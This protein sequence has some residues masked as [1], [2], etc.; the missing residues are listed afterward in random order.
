MKALRSLQKR[1]QGKYGFLFSGFLSWCGK[2]ETIKAIH[3][4]PAGAD[5]SEDAGHLELANAY[6]KMGM[7]EDA[8]VQYGILAQ[9]YKSSGM[10]DRALMVM[11]LM[12]RIDSSKSGSVKGIT[13]LKHSTKLKGGGAVNKRS[14][15][16]AIQEASIHAKG[17]EAAFDLRAELEIGRSEGISGYKEIEASEQGPGCT[18]IFRKPTTSSSPNSMDPKSNYNVGL[19]WLESGSID[20]AI[21]QFQIAYEKG[22][23]PFESARLLG[24]CFKEKTMWAEASQAFQEA[25]KVG[26]I[27]QGDTLAMKCE[28]GLILKEQGKTEEALELFRETSAVEQTFRNATAGDMKKSARK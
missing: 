11:A 24:L 9:H 16:G 18:E 2:K 27:S 10:E 21:A 25:L 7:R 6:L 4:K 12:A 14:E 22:E 3:K 5:P 15:A 19:A 17:K 1:S 26:G 28:L 23:N 8:L 13:G 20:D